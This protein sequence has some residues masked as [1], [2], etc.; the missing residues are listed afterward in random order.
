LKTPYVEYEPAFSPDGRWIAYSSFESG[1]MSVYVPPFPG[2]GGQ[3]LV[4]GPN[5]GTLGM[6]P[7]W[8]RKGRELF[9]ESSL[10]TRIMVVSYT[11]KGDTFGA[12]K[13]RVWSDTRILEVNNIFW[14]LDLAP[15]GKHFA[16][17]P[18]P[19]TGQ[20]KGSVHVTVILNFLDEMRQK[21]PLER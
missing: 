6:H 13:P 14:N 21:M 16:V 12:E 18:R 8:S 7:I 2:P 1:V 15:D 10:D 20:Q 3:W 4:S 11:A 17:F 9:Y 5:T 19:E